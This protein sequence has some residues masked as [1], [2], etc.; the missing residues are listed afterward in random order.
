M[1]S[2]Y[3]FQKQKQKLFT[4]PNMITMGRIALTPI[5]FGSILNQDY[6]TSI[7]LLAAATSSDYLDGYIARKYN[8]SSSFGS[9]L[10][11]FADKFFVVS[12]S[13]ALYHSGMM[14]GYLFATFVGRDLALLGTS[15]FWRYKTLEEPKTFKRMYSLIQVPSPQIVPTFTSKVN[16]SLQMG[17]IVLKITNAYMAWDIPFEI[18][19]RVVLATSLW[20]MSQYIFYPSQALKKLKK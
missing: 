20:A 13:I 6:S 5:L 18:F 1:L 12:M 16:T 19:E 3:R 17:Y 10:D 2:L 4:L 15:I 8:M 9:F 14:P 7:V 11:P